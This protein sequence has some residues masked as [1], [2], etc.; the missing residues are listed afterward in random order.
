MTVTVTAPR[1]LRVRTVDVT[2]RFAASE[3]LLAMVP[4]AVPS[5]SVCAWVRE[6]DGLVG[7]GRA[8][9]CMPSGPDRFDAAEQWWSG[10][11]AQAQVD[12]AVRLPGTGLVAFGSFSFAADSDAASRLVVPSRI[13][14]RRDG[15]TW[16][17]TVTD[18]DGATQGPPPGEPADTPAAP[19]Q[20]H[21]VALVDG[22]VPAK[23]W[24]A[25]IS[26][27][28]QRIEAGDV[29]KVVL[30]RDVLVE[31]TEPIDLRRVLR[32]LSGRYCAT[33]TF[34]VDGLVGAT[35][36]MLVRLLGG[37]ARSRVLAGTVRRGTGPAPLVTE[38]HPELDARHPSDP[39]L[40]L[41]SS[42][43][44]LEEHAFAVRSVAEALGPHCRSLDVP[45]EP[46]VLELPDVY[47]LASDI[48][49]LVVD[50]ATSLRLAAALHPSA[51]V[52]GTPAAAA[53]TVI[54]EL[55]L[56]DRGRYAGPVGWIDASGEGDWGIALR[57]GELCPDG[58]RMRLFA[59]GGIVAASDP[60][61][62]L[63]ETEIK[64]AAMRYA[65]D[66]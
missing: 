46:F 49:G 22:S 60:E 59:G 29:D 7:W 41:V 10:V 8:A 62:E 38:A 44:D 26:R 53:A 32:R 51:A 64:L 47:H 27:A 65:L 56:M 17:T 35:P 63:A 6:G 45:V 34:A 30:A 39:R 28:V 43:K 42:D 3:E 21:Q 15:R 58:R 57:C 4:A 54:S 5:G 40:R 13:L 11:A 18:A 25:L 1:R 50:G 31:S 61:A 48:T 2:G 23:E 33:W 66:C 12:D 19:T 36:E 37:K 52:C 55:E 16:L 20:A 24:P 14:G 9:T